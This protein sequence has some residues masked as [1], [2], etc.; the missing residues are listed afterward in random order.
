MELSEHADEPGRV[1]ASW[2]KSVY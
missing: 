1:T 2:E